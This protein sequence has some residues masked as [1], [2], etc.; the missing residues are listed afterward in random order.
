VSAQFTWRV[1]DEAD[2]TRTVVNRPAFLPQ[3]L[4][5][6]EQMF[7]WHRHLSQER[8]NSMKPAPKKEILDYSPGGRKE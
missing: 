1:L 6:S 4:A 3:T 5:F 7:F 8:Y 2:G